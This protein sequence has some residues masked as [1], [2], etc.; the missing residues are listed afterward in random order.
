M[1]DDPDDEAVRGERARERGKG[2]HGDEQI[3]LTAFRSGRLYLAR[4][5]MGASSRSSPGIPES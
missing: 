5:V 4:C 3:K 2:E 1:D